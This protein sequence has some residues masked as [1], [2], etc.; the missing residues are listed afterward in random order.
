MEQENRLGT[1]KITKLVVS[2]ALPSMLAQ[3]V[4]VLYSIIDRIFVGNIEEIGDLC[5]AGIGVCAPI[6]TLVAAF[7]VF[8]GIGG[9]PLLGIALGEKNKKKAEGVLANSFILLFG[10]SALVTI[11][12][13]SAKRP[14]LIMSGASE[15]II[16][17]ADQYFT[18]CMSGI[19]FQLFAQGMYQ[20]IIAQG[21]AKIGMVS[22]ILGAVLNIIF[23]PLFIYV[24]HL[25]IA[26]AAYATILS[27]F[28]SAV[29]VLTYLF[30]KSDI[31]ITFH[32]YKLKT[33][34]KICRLGVSPFLIIGTDSVVLIAVNATLK[35]YGGAN[36]DFLI[37]VNT[38]VQSFMLVI[39]MPLG[40]IS[41]GTQCILAYNYGAANTERVK[42][43]ENVIGL[44]CLAYTTIFFI[45]A[46]TVGNYFIMLFT[47]VPEIAAE[48]FR[49]IKIST[50]A[51]IPL[52]LQYSIVDGFTALGQVGL[53]CFLSLFR[54]T[55]YFIIVMVIPH[56]FNPNNI[57]FAE[58][59]STIITI[60]ITVSMFF[61]FNNKILKK[62][63]NYV[64]T[65][66]LSKED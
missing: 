37:T 24:F 59:I 27:Q 57:F 47:D 11:I 64:A 7:S 5:L 23:D 42:K 34:L 26:G 28:A 29:F 45:L 14:L 2:I 43:A 12:C 53:S 63:E 1:E 46:W 20:F 22:I 8:V 48:A 25:G 44:L 55:T 62:R 18:I 4:S 61:I 36:A 51:I 15:N 52:A 65:H 38:I 39:T 35:N 58:P 17:Y 16:D 50:L 33:I 13:L 6:L 3:F 30:T 10:I 32:G 40:G 19:T 49:A 54:K 9:G 41:G 60:V 66:D 21:K 31:K 56:L